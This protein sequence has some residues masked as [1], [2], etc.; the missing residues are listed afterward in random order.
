[1]ADP[2]GGVPAPPAWLA[3]SPRFSYRRR[4]GQGAS[5]VVVEAFDAWRGGP[6]ALKAL[7]RPGSAAARAALATHFRA[8]AALDHPCLVAPYELVDDR[9]LALLTMPVVAGKPL[10]ELLNEQNVASTHLLFGQ[11]TLDQA[12]AR[13]A[14]ARPRPTPLVRR[15][16]G[17]VAEGLAA[18]HRAGLCHGDVRPDNALV[19]DD[20]GARLIDFGPWVPGELEG[21]RRERPPAYLAPE[22]SPDAPPSAADDC[23][24]FGV[25]LF[26][27]LTGHLPFAGS[28][29]DVTMRKATL[30]PPRPSFLARNVEP[31]LDALAV[32][33]LA[34][35]PGD[36][37]SAA[38]ASALLGGA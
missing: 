1:M 15:A 30:P 6:V 17:H 10:G 8:L 13:A 23:Y 22:L 3:D 28:A 12:A 2:P 34:R 25:L 35:D 33:L 18:L 7:G 20:G 26:E 29:L 11:P 4:L 19:A 31:A 24:A 21:E 32:A 38:E 16:L 27:A 36:R 9:G 14:A 5:G 37:P